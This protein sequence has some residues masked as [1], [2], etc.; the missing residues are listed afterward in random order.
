MQGRK[1]LFGVTGSIAACKAATWVSSLVKEEAQ[2]TVM[3]TEAATRFVTPLTFGA[4]SGHQVYNNMFSTDAE[5]IM[6]HIT[7]S[8]DADAVLIAPATAQTIA[9][10]AQG[11]ADNLLSAAVL[12]SAAPVVVCPAMNSKMLAHPAT[13]RNLAILKEL[14]Y[15]VVE[16]E[17]GPLAC[18][19]VGTGRLAEWDTVREVLQGLFV[20]QDLAGQQ[21]L[22]TAG[23]T[24]E[25]LDPAR[26]LSNRSS[27]KMGYFLARTA[28][29]RGAEVTLI[30]GPTNLPAPPGITL[31]PVQT[32]AEMAKAVKEHAENASII[33]KAAAVADFRPKNVA[34]LKIKKSTAALQLELEPNQDILAN[35]GKG[36]V[37]R[38]DQLLVGFAAES[39]NHEAEGRRKLEAKQADLIVVNDILG[40]Q[41]GFDVD[42]NQVTF[43]TQEGAEQLALLSKEETANRIWDK[44][45][46]LHKSKRG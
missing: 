33:V 22:I 11:M 19:E 13:Q 36:K 29:R 45:I 5:E 21:I 46:A 18:G 44:V 37:Q 16:P 43:I 31:V 15:L 40:K 24:R 38:P 9:Q 42:T 8:G 27:G 3:M 34:S 39:N 20:E 12:A 26:Y 6:A 30:S 32:A 10:L 35:L 1:I 7:L 41:T 2:V 14:G 4:L 17:T 25:P 23:P 28:R